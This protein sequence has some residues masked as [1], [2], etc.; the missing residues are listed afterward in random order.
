MAH[1]SEYQAP[2]H[3]W[4]DAAKGI[5]II[6]VVMMHTTLGLGEDLG[7]EGWMHHVVAFSKPFRM[8]DFFLISGLFLSR[9]IDRDWR[10]YA[11]KRVVHFAY[12]YVL[13]LL[14]QSALKY[15][16]L[17]GGS[18]AGFAAHLAHSL[19]EPFGTLW[20]IYLLAVFSVVTKLLKGLP[21]WVL[22]AA[23]AILEALPIETGHVL[24]DE[25]A[26]RWV[27]FLIGYLYAGRVFDLARQAAGQ[28]VAALAALAA[29]GVVNGVLAMTGTG[30][31]HAPTYAA[32]PGVSLALG[33]AGSAAIVT[34]AALLTRAGL[35][36]PLAYC[37]RHS[38]A[39]YLAFFLPM[40][41]LRIAAARSGVEWD[42]GWAA[43]AITLAA[44]VAPLVLERAV[45]HTPLSFLF[46]RPAAFRLKPRAAAIAPA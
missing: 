45:R 26:A 39:I 6:L 46:S 14:I 17:S 7:R 3:D 32:L 27:Y 9:V 2:R 13:W 25:F 15:G 16:S 36:A 19:V 33:L 21:A 44:V 37:G 42:V 34:V 30:I 10:T 1:A 29:W 4:V 5:C 40:A 8:P 43:A 22:V 31:A 35:E 24:I 41:A 20:F 18:P 11:D 38:I 12:F 23:G 28:P